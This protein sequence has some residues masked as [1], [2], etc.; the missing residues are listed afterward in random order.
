[1]QTSNSFFS[2]I[3]RWNRSLILVSLIVLLGRA[4]PS[5][6]SAGW[7]WP[8]QAGDYQAEAEREH[9]AAI[10]NKQRAEAADH[11]SEIARK[12]ASNIT[13]FSL[14]FFLLS[15]GSIAYL[16][17]TRKTIVVRNEIVEKV[18][19]NEVIQKVVRE[20][21][22]VRSPAHE[23]VADTL[24]IDGTNVIY[25]TPSHQNPSLLNLL[26]LLLE[27]QKRKCAFKCFLDACT[28]YKFKST[29]EVDALRDICRSFP[30][31]FIIAPAG[32]RA[33]DYILDDA[34]R[35]GTPII[36]NDRFLDYAETYPWLKSDPQRRVPFVMHSGSVQIVAL[37]I[38]A[39]IPTDLAMADSSLRT[40]FA[41]PVVAK[42]PVA[43][44]GVGNHAH[45]NGEM[46]QAAA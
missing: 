12:H 42:D 3:V 2:N 35:H 13:G 21:V 33:D 25:G 46:M 11:N 1:M 6:A 36:S 32:I 38:Q 19:K 40:G 29:E 26:G 41:E 45:V 7:A 18:V 16:I 30:S 43:S 9:A 4:T 20:E 24:V 22:I 31:T 28:F 44:N 10:I 14:M 34:H 5:T 37:G 17:N 23:L 39:S 8:W 15:A 27:L